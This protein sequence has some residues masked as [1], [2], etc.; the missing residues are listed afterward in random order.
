[1][2]L[3]YNSIVIW[4]KTKDGIMVSIKLVQ[5]IFVFLFCITCISTGMCNLYKG[6]DSYSSYPNTTYSISSSYGFDKRIDAM[7]ENSGSV[8]DQMKANILSEARE[9]SS[10]RTNSSNG[11][12]PNIFLMV[13]PFA[14][15]IVLKILLQNE[16]VDKMY[17]IL[18]I[19]NSDGKKG[20]SISI[21]TT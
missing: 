6:A 20:D 16:F 8:T 12:I 3:C 2:R 14:V 21:L 10:S 7:N 1:M 19:H 11:F 9:I 17:M 18:F 4:S 5:R 15:G 13:I